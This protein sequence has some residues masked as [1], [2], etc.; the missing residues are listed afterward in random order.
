LGGDDL[1]R[2]QGVGGSTTTVANMAGLA[3][4][5]IEITPS[6]GGMPDALAH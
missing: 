6:R 2:R 1:I 4:G 5:R 3:R